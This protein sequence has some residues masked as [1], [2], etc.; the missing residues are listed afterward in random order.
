MFRSII[1]SS[2]TPPHDYVWTK[3]EQRSKQKLRKIRKSLHD[4]AE[5]LDQIAKD[6]LKYTQELLK[7]KKTVEIVPF[8]E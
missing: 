5:S 1:C 2:T 7:E 8:D 6:D 3:H 4:F